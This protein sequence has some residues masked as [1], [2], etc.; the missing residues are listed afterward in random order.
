LAAEAAPA[1]LWLGPDPRTVLWWQPVAA[2]YSGDLRAGANNPEAEAA[3]HLA[4]VR[5]LRA[6]EE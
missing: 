5:S 3:V 1:A 2:L 6:E 4:R